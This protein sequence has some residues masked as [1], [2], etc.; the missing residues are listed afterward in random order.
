MGTTG[1]VPTDFGLSS[2]RNGLGFS[3]DSDSRKRK[4][5]RHRHLAVREPAFGQRT[6]LPP[7][8][9]YRDNQVARIDFEGEKLRDGRKTNK[10]TSRLDNSLWT[11]VILDSS[12]GIFIFFFHFSPIRIVGPRT[13]SSVSHVYYRLHAMGN[14]RPTHRAS[15]ATNLK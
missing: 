1:I 10:I 15:F 13:R 5:F 7:E 8:R 2:P 9:L 4:Q 12:F 3:N 14:D 11:W 6:T